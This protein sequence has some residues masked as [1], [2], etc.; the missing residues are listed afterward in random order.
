MTMGIGAY[1]GDDENRQSVT[2]TKME[3]GYSVEWQEKIERAFPDLQPLL[4][5]LPEKLRPLALTWIELMKPFL[6]GS[7]TFKGHQKLFVSLKAALEWI[8]AHLGGNR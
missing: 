7:H 6:D 8:D 1:Y 3:D 2:I 4:D 5:S